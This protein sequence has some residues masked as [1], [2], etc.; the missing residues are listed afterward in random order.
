MG[1]RYDHRVLVPVDVLGGES[2]PSTVIEALASV[3]VVLLGYRE[4]PDQTATEQARAEFGDRARVKLDELASAF[5]AAG[6]PVTTR[7]VF[8]HDRFETFERVALADG[9]DAV[10]L[11]NPA[12]GLERV[13]VAIR[14]GVNVEYIVE[15]VAAVF[16]DTEVGVTIFHVAESDADRDRKREALDEAAATLVERGIGRD[17]I[18][19]T[20]A[21]D[22]SPTD[23]IVDAADDHDLLVV[24]ESR[25]SIRRFIFRDRAKRIARR[26]VDPVLVIRGE[27][28]EADDEPSDVGADIETDAEPS[29]TDETAEGQEP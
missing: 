23:A 11:P 6:C 13:L 27:Y 9:C 8:T 18:D 21:I 29:N 20:V 2:V 1:N 10:L 4:I 24:G 7:L 26:T 12:P 28:L 17:R 25:P 5:E 16:A 22:G 19:V 14:G 3:P 15:L